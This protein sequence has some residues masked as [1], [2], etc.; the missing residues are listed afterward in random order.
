[1]D[2]QNRSTG[3]TPTRVI[4]EL[5]RRRGC[6]LLLGALV[7]FSVMATNPGASI[8]VPVEPGQRVELEQPSGETVPAK[9]FGDEWYHGLETANGFTDPRGPTVG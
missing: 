8:A 7:L 6:H 9:P 3:T 2:T 5:A 4:K 1:M